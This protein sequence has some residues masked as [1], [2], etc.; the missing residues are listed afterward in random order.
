[1]AVLFFLCVFLV[2]YHFVLYPLLVMGAGKMVGKNHVSVSIPSDEELPTVSVLVTCCNE[3]SVILDKLANIKNQDYPADKIEIVFAA[4]GLQGGV[5]Q[6]LADHI[7]GNVKLFEYEENRGKIFVLNDTVPQCNGD[8]IVFTDVSAQLE[9]DAIQKL[10]EEL[11]VPGVGGACGYHRV[12]G[13]EGNQA[14]LSGPQR[15]YWLIDGMVKSAEN[16]LGSITSCYGS[17]YAI[18][19]ELFT[20]LP[21]SVTDD[22]YQAMGIVR[23]GW[24]FVFASKARARIMPRA[25]SAKHEVSRRRRVVIRSLRGL[26]E[27]RE[28]FSIFKYG[29]YSVTLFSHKVLRRV[30]PVL[31]VLILLSTSILAVESPFWLVI[32][33][34]QLVTYLVAAFSFAGCFESISKTKRLHKPIS[35]ATY[36]VLGQLGTLLGMIDFLR[37]KRVD[38]WAPAKN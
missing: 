16:R 1:M 20:L 17:I 30:I 6:I 11:L 14:K 36:F 4:D 38:R 3:G 29:I 37:G 32:F 28:L 34:M 25:K 22:A 26:W 31:L 9:T 27:S 24:R 13:E 7:G 19:R 10:V 8:I 15:L 33:L 23:Q 35:F 5:G 2:V 12:V 18:R 21:S